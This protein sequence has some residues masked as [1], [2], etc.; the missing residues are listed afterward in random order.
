MHFVLYHFYKWDVA[1]MQRRCSWLGPVCSWA[2]RWPLAAQVVANQW[3]APFWEC[4]PTMPCCLFHPGPKVLRLPSSTCPLDRSC[5]HPRFP[6]NS[7]QCQE[8]CSS[9]IHESIYWIILVKQKKKKN[10]GCVL[11]AGKFDSKQI[12][13]QIRFFWVD[14]PQRFS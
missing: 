6:H 1:E 4:C 10:K 12:P 14:W 9:W 7:C 2:L 11:T 3:Q 8:L 13:P 5:R